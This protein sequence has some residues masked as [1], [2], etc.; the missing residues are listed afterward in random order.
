MV[1]T[2]AF[3]VTAA[4]VLFQQKRII[5]E[6]NQRVQADNRVLA[7]QRSKAQELARI[8][9]IERHAA[10]A[11]ALATTAGRERDALTEALGAFDYAGTAT[12]GASLGA[13][14]RRATMAASRSRIVATE[15][16]SM[17]AVA[18]TADGR[19][20]L[21]GGEGGRL[22]LFPVQTST[23]AIV[24]R[25]PGQPIARLV[26][27]S[28]RAVVLVGPDDPDAETTA[29]TL[30]L[31][32]LDRK[33]RIAIQEDLGRLTGAS[34]SP[35]GLFV[36]GW[37]DRTMALWRT[38]DGRLIWRR[39]FGS[40][41]EDVAFRTDREMVVGTQAGLHRL[42]GSRLVWSRTA[43][44]APRSVYVARDGRL[45]GALATPAYEGPQLHVWTEGGRYLGCWEV[46]SL[47]NEAAV[48]SERVDELSALLK[49]PEVAQWLR[50][51]RCRAPASFHAPEYAG[52][53]ITPADDG[54][55][56]W[57][58][59]GDQLVTGY[60][61]GSAR[62][63]TF[64]AT[65][66]RELVRHGDAPIARVS[67]SPDG[68]YFATASADHTA[69]VWDRRRSVSVA[70]LIGH[71]GPVVDVAIHPTNDLAATASADG[72]VRL[73]AID[74]GADF[75]VSRFDEL[76]HVSITAN[77]WAGAK[78][79]VVYLSGTTTATVEVVDDV[80]RIAVSP[81]GHT[82][83]VATG[84]GTYVVR[85]GESARRIGAAEYRR[86]E[87]ATE[88]ALVA[89]SRSGTTAIFDL[90]A[91]ESARTLST[92]ASD[93]VV[94]ASS[95]WILTLGSARSPRLVPFDGPMS[96]SIDL[97]SPGSE[98]S[99]AGVVVDSLASAFLGRVFRGRARFSEDG[100]RLVVAQ[101]E[102]GVRVWD[103]T[104][105]EPTQ[106]RRFGDFEGYDRIAISADYRFVAAAAARVGVHIWRVADGERVAFFPAGAS[107]VLDIRFSSDGEHL[108]AAT[109]FG[110][111][112]YPVG[113][114]AWV[115]RACG[116]VGSRRRS[117][118]EVCGVGR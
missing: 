61:N 45:V 7:A 13:A 12:L 48:V 97:E 82:V 72:T 54:I 116:L 26:A 117:E 99:L 109:A 17:T 35:S 22:T 30:E 55:T 10:R 15:R 70:H 108:M 31:Y 42:K 64:R 83:A 39:S 78:G 106:V 60:A 110:V 16:R 1:G 6:Q 76:D 53:M 62:H 56:A 28:D 100:R 81:S 114:A 112:R 47:P 52:I 46:A 11:D 115:R 74:T 19:Y 24:M 79:R 104:G 51:P 23:E 113:I 68:D 91:L 92:V 65:A 5:D 33:S 63:W 50:K 40:R 67:F 25:G 43:A 21:A 44:V 77:G 49:D 98:P 14:L 36:A 84:S 9:R 27:A 96:A 69:V 18:F 2:A 85:A 86:V 38:R 32:A 75:E 58:W 89:Q 4:V 80:D 20:L 101:A 90:R 88:H 34:M 94:V 118:L 41:I 103:V 8:Q 71:S 73:W 37:S 95:R 107:P 59:F 29:Y 111:R 105:A 87:F 66:H 102:E 57:A 93:D 3:A